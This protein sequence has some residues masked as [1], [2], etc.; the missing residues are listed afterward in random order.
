MITGILL[1]AIITFIA[2]ISYKRPRLENRVI[3]NIPLIDWINIFIVPLF[4]YI[5]LTLMA[6]NILS[7]DRATILDFDD[8]T[9]LSFG[10]FFLVYAFVGNSIHFVSKVLSRYIPPQKH[11]LVYRIN[12]I[13]HGK[14][15]HYMIFLSSLMVMFILALLEINYPIPSAM[16]GGTEVV[17]L[18]AGLLFGISA[19]KVVFHTS[20]WFGGYNKP[21]FFLVG[22]LLFILV[23][24]FPIFD[25]HFLFYPITFFVVTMF[26]AFIG[27][28]FIRQLLIFLR[29]GKKRRL[30]FL[31]KILSV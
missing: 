26:S 20:S 4:V 12:E 9:L 31:A 27:T 29:L 11:F 21:L 8:F 13:F 18:L 6:R 5:G 22:F 25:L 14:L 17:V 1:L 24:L 2:V 7:R 23:S 10:I 15:S 30:Q 19:T 3:K 16:H 28:F